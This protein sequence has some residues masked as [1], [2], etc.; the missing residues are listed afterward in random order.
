MLVI[1]KMVLVQL[2]IADG[3]AYDLRDRRDEPRKNVQQIQGRYRAEMS[4]YGIDP[5]HTEYARAHDY[6]NS[7]RKTFPDPAAGRNRA[8]HESAESIGKTH[9]PRALKAC[10]NDCF[11]IG[12]PR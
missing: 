6:N 10:F 3:K 8:V 2:F 12:K 5:R 11:L 4:K 9:D 1:G 7:R